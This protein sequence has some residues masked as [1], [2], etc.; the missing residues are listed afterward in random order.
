[1]FYFAPVIALFFA[2]MSFVT[3]LIF[4]GTFSIINAFSS[5][6]LPLSHGWNDGRCNR[7]MEDIMRRKRDGCKLTRKFDLWSKVDDDID[8]STSQLQVSN[9]R[10]RVLIP[11]KR[12]RDLIFGLMAAN[13]ALLTPKLSNAAGEIDNKTGEL[14]TPKSQM[15]SGVGSDITRGVGSRERIDETVKYIEIYNTRFITYLS[16]FLLYFDE[17]ASEFWRSSIEI[18]VRKGANPTLVEPKIFAQFAES[19]EIGLYDY[20]SGPY[21]SYSSVKAAKAGISSAIP[22]KS[23][24]AKESKSAKQGILNLLA[25][26]KAR[27]TKE[28][29][30]RQLAILFS[31]LDGEG[32]K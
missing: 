5:S 9:E 17:S 23:M 16:R 15:L 2:R 3:F 20:F 26:L 4:C 24:S 18:Q 28:E 31:L 27:Y 6:L 10:H 11:S 7:C 32:M 1:M 30:K 14:F 19:V 29:C 25:L 13:T 8:S 12:R 21:G 22:E